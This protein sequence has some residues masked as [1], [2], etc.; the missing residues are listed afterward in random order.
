MLPI[1]IIISSIQTS[2]VFNGDINRT[3]S[4]RPNININPSQRQ[5]QSV[6]MN[7]GINQSVPTTLVLSCHIEQAGVHKPSLVFSGTHTNYSNSTVKQQLF[8]HS[9]VYNNVHNNFYH[10]H[11]KTSASTSTLSPHKFSSSQYHQPNSFIRSRCT[12]PWTNVVPKE[13]QV[14]V[15]L[16]V[17]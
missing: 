17:L 16:M 1:I 7:E 15:P 4:I 13:E 8:Y 5:H 14:L 9:Q 6:P 2:Y 12:L 10:S 11:I 3:T